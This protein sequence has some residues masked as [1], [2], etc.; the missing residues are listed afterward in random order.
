MSRRTIWIILWMNLWPYWV[1]AKCRPETQTVMVQTMTDTLERKEQDSLAS[2]NSLKYT[3]QKRYRPQGL[4]FI[5]H[6]FSDHLYFQVY[7]GLEKITPRANRF[8]HGGPHLG[9]AAGKFL[10]PANSLL[11]ALTGGQFYHRDDNS[12][13]NLYGLE[14]SHRF[15]LL[16]YL[17]GYNPRRLFDLSTLEGI[18]YRY[19]SYRGAGK[20]NAELHLGVNLDFRMSP[21]LRLYLEPRVTFLTD[22]I[23]HSY[24][25]NWHRYDVS[26]QGCMGITW[27][28][29]DHLPDEPKR[30]TGGRPTFLELTLGKQFQNSQLVR[31]KIGVLNSTGPHFQLA[32][33]KWY[34]HWL[35]W[36]FSVFFSSDTW[37]RVDDKD[38]RTTL[39]SGIRSE[40]MFD[41]LALG[42]RTPAYWSV[43]PFIGPEIGYMV[44]KEDSGDLR[45]VYLGMT[46]GVQIKYHIQK[47]MAVFVE[48]RTSVIPYSHR[49]KRV[50]SLNTVY[51]RRSYYDQVFNGSIGFAF[52][53]H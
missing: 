14:I 2:F 17:N 42:K 11:V 15:H 8:F 19:S 24:Q 4:P 39:Y 47:N 34:T 37:D 31:D 53:L 38:D 32:A 22:G 33:G 50:T 6:K 18:G 27:L 35:A 51:V 29:N 21:R 12:R 40:M 28:M 26:Y 44:K 36:R 52:R 41:L 43:A 48:A 46:A 30:T 20:H 49:E 23:D 16:H 5:N 13:M 7:G 9:I 25:H 1:M 3:M 10:N 45:K